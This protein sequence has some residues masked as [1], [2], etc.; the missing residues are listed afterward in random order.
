MGGG[1]HRLGGDDLAEDRLRRAASV[2][3]LTREHLVEHAAERVDVGSRAGRPVRGRLL[4]AHVVRRAEA[5]AG[6]GQ[7]PAPRVGY[8]QGDSEVRH[9]RLPVLQEDVLGLHVAVDHPLPMGVAERHGDRA[10]DPDRLPHGQ[11]ALPVEA[12]PQALP[13]D[14]GHHVEEEALRLPRVEQRQDVRVLEVGGRLDLGQ[15]ALGAHHGGQL[16]LQDLERH[17]ALVLEVVSQVNGGHPAL[18]DLADDLVAALQG[19]VQA[20]DGVGHGQDPRRHGTTCPM[21]GSAAPPRTGCR[22]LAG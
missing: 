13:I 18:A 17:L 15:K 11:L 1:T 9:D 21:L 6:L 8:R 20:G 3:R 7:A 14:E 19:G 2:R 10:R 22:S 5:H 4:R 12:L 16:R